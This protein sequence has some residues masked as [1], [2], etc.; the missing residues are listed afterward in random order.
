MSDPTARIVSDPGIL[1]GKPRIRGTRLAVEH[2]IAT[3]NAGDSDG[4]VLA[5]YPALEQADLDACRA[6]A[7]RWAAVPVAEMFDPPAGMSL[8]V[9]VVIPSPNFT[10]PTRGRDPRAIVL[11]T[12]ESPERQGAARGVAQNWFARPDAQASAHYV[13][14][15]AEVV[16]CVPETLIAWHARGFN[17]HS[18][19]LEIVGAA[20]QSAAGWG[21]EYSAATL[22]LAA[23]LCADIARRWRIPIEARDSAGLIAAK[24]AWDAGQEARELGGIT[25]HAAVSAAFR[26]SDHGDPGPTFPMPWF[27]ERVRF[28]AGAAQ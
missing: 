3:L 14:D 16:A 28:H 17:Q 8:P 25:T 27:L 18:I 19:G 24:R 9:V 20:G 2:V 5:A 21:D 22:D 13:V 10:T 1:G 23:R 4:D 12:T 26:K 11:H 6:H 15:A 7:K